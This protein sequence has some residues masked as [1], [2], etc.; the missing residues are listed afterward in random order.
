M[1]IMHK[2]H[3]ISIHQSGGLF[4]YSNC[5]CNNQ[6]TDSNSIEEIVLITIIQCLC[7]FY[8]HGYL[9]V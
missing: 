1:Y 8:M 9:E 3:V 2:I 5:N 7:V 4:K 6:V